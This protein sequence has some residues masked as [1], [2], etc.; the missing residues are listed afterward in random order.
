[1][2]DLQRVVPGCVYVVIWA[3]HGSEPCGLENG[4]GGVGEEDAV[5]PLWDRAGDVF[6]IEIAVDEVNC[7][8]GGAQAE[9]GAGQGEMLREGFVLHI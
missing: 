6:A 7:V 9:V 4:G 8:V 3:T 1:M 2:D 5:P